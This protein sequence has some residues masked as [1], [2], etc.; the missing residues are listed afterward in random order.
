MSTDAVNEMVNRLAT[1]PGVGRVFVEMQDGTTDESGLYATIAEQETLGLGV[2]VLIAQA[3]AF[4]G[5]GQFGKARQI[6][7]LAG[8]LADSSHESDDEE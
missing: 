6:L 4:I 1:L 5:A 3:Q 8:R 2:A 7:D